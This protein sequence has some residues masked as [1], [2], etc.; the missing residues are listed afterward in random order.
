MIQRPKV[1][2]IIACYNRAHIVPRA[3]Q[4]ALSQNYE[5]LEVIVADDG[6]SDDSVAVA[7]N[8]GATV[9]P[10]EHVGPPGIRNV[11]VA[12]SS[13]DYIAFLDADDV[14]TEGSLSRRMG[15]FNKVDAGLVFADAGIQSGGGTYFGGRA[16][17]LEMETEVIGDGDHVIVSDPVPFLLK[18]SFVLTSTAIVS[19][20]AWNDAGGFDSELL[21]AEDFDLWLR[22]GDRHKFAYTSSTAALYE[23]HEDSMSRKRRFV[24]E[25]LVKAWTKHHRRYWDKYPKL[26]ELLS[27]SLG[28][29]AYEA[30]VVVAGENDRKLAREYFGTAIR[31]LPTFKSAWAGYARTLF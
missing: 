3:I 31:C 17:L 5:P 24:A 16:E 27:S 1:S 28:S 14:W 4:S 11:G 25:G 19:R 7:R 2:V 23:Q 15:L 9:I 20:R 30:G 26:R 29:C 12:A 18:R 22:I 13:G 10:H 8:C 21:F 6:S